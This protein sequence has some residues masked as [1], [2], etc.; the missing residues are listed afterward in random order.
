MAEHFPALPKQPNIQQQLTTTL[1]NKVMKTAFNRTRDYVTRNYPLLLVY[2]LGA[3]VTVLQ[4]R[5]LL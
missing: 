5:S 3:T 4:L 2:L 1:M